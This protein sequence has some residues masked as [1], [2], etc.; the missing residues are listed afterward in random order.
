[1]DT[2][3]IVIEAINN[4]MTRLQT[5]EYLV[6]ALVEQGHDEVTASQV[7]AKSLNQIW[8]AIPV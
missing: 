7:A 1:M 6:L 3:E 2:A 5:F 8:E 4:G